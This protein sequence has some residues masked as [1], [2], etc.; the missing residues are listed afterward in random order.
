VARIGK[1]LSLKGERI[2]GDRCR[3][4]AWPIQRSY[5]DLNSGL[6]PFQAVAKRQAQ[7]SAESSCA[8]HTP[9]RFWKN[10]HGLVRPI[11]LTRPSALGPDR[12]VVPLGGTKLQSCAMRVRPAATPA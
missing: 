9:L 5:P 7:S 1:A 8:S 10:T 4:P 6:V 12:R 2:G 3:T 11:L